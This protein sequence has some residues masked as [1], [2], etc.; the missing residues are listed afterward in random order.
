MIQGVC[1]C[2]YKSRLEKIRI[3]IRG[4]KNKLYRKLRGKQQ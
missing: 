3:N 1:D 2:E 4:M